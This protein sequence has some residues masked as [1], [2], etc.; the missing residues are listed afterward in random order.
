MKQLVRLGV[1]LCIVVTAAIHLYLAITA[2]LPMFYANAIGFLVLGAA[3]ANIGLSLPR[4]RVVV[5]LQVYTIITVVLWVFVGERTSIAYIDKIAELLI[6]GLL[7][8]EQR[9]D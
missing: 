5:A 6:V 2:T 4:E 7:W 8:Y 9:I 1:V 3:Y